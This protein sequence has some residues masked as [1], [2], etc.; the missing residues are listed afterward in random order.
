M[1]SQELR[2]TPRKAKV[3]VARK[4]DADDDNDLDA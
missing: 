1:F 3:P 2:R 4:S